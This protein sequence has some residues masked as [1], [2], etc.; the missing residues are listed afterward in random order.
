MVHFPLLYSRVDMDYSPWSTFRCPYYGL[1]TMDY[2]PWSTF[3]CP[4]Y[5]LGTMDY[6]SMGQLSIGHIQMSIYTMDYSLCIV[7]SP[8]S[9]GHSRRS[10]PWTIVHGPHSIGHNGLWSMV[11]FPLDML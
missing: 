4:Y 1:G 3:R 8:L 11:N 9:V 5:G 10:I 6:T 2:S 7:H